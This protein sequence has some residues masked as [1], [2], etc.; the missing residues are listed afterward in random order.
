MLFRSK[1]DNR[2]I[3]VGTRYSPDVAVR[4]KV[5]NR[6][7]YI[8]LSDSDTY[9]SIRRDFSL[10]TWELEKYNEQLVISNLEPGQVLYLQP[11][12]RK[13]EPGISH[14]VIR[15]GETMYSVSQQYAVKLESL[16]EM[17]F[18]DKGTEPEIGRKI[19]LR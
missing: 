15:E 10:L 14:H 19:N 4:V 5:K 3:P 7:E 11:K 17:N 8:I 9:E 16:Y 12:R 13:A 18:M 2:L 6:V 1:A